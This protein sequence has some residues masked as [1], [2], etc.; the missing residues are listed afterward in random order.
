MLLLSGPI[1]EK[2]HSVALSTR[3]ISRLDFTR[4]Q[5][6]IDDFDINPVP[7]SQGSLARGSHALWP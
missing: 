1:C 3:S 7:I 6:I 5:E 2:P 4:N